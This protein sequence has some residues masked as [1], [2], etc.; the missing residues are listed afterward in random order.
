MIYR[1]IWMIELFQLFDIFCIMRG[2]IFKLFVHYLL[3]IFCSD[4]KLPTI[5]F[6]ALL[7]FCC[8]HTVQCMK[9]LKFSGQLTEIPA[10]NFAD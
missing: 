6:F 2:I 9:L 1:L 3:F 5:N 4:R 8:L 10:E 7:F